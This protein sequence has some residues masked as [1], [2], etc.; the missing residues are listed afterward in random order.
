MIFMLDLGLRSVCD[1]LTEVCEHERHAE[2]MEA[3]EVFFFTSM[4]TIFIR[5]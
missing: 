2:P 3:Q 4:A 1:I 5:P